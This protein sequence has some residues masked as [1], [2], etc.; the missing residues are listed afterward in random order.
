[1]YPIYIP[2]FHIFVMEKEI[3]SVVEAE[4]KKEGGWKT[5]EKKIAMFAL[6]EALKLLEKQEPQLVEKI[7]Q[8]L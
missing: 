6:E 7:K 5:I 2:T 4:V 8:L 3:K 1:M